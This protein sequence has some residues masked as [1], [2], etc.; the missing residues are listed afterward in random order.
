[1][2]I[3]GVSAHFIQ[4]LA[5]LTLR[6]GLLM[7]VWKRILSPVHMY[8]DVREQ[9]LELLVNLA[10]I[11][12]QADDEG[13][14]VDRRRIVLV[15]PR[16]VCLLKGQA[17]PKGSHDSS[18]ASACCIRKQSEAVALELLEHDINVYRED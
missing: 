1:M 13:G 12:W 8:F 18:L 10:N 16:M 3:R 7:R 15:F 2:G 6:E 4:S 5:E 17:S 9:S 11:L 14:S